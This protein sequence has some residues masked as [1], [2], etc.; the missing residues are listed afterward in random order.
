MFKQARLSYLPQLLTPPCAAPLPCTSHP[1][2]AQL[3]HILA[4][5]ELCF[6]A[7]AKLR[8]EQRALQQQLRAAEHSPDALLNSSADNPLRPWLERLACSLEREHSLRM[9]LDRCVG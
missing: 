2:H 6:S 5:A 3:S 8:D 4:C 7:R 1:P 9:M